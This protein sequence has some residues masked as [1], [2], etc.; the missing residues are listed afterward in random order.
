MSRREVLGD[1]VEDLRTLVAGELAPCAPGVRRL[2]RVADVLPVAFTGLAQRTAGAIA[3]DASVPRI[4]ARLLA[5][6]EQLRG[7]VD[8]GQRAG[9]GGAGGAGGCQ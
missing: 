8:G 4:G 5:A 6:D 3:N 2:D 7:A 9:A 1:V